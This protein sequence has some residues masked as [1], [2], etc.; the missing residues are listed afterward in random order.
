MSLCW[1]ANLL[2][3]LNLEVLNYR[4]ITLEYIKSK[5]VNKQKKACLLTLLLHCLKAPW[6]IKL[7]R[8]P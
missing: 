2:K 6:R 8:K 3:M 1:R 7:F 5:V 4:Q